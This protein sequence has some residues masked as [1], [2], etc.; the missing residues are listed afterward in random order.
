MRCVLIVYVYA[1]D[2]CEKV[3]RVQIML[4]LLYRIYGMVWRYSDGADKKSKVNE[5][6]IYN[7]TVCF[8]NV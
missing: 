1:K 6:V 7:V 4:L 8:Y 5:Y 2:A 3:W